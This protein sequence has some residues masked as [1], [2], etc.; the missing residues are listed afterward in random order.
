MLLMCCQV[1]L[2]ARSPKHYTSCVMILTCIDWLHLR[3]QFRT[4]SWYIDM[5]KLNCP[6]N[7]HFIISRLKLWEKKLKE[8]FHGKKKNEING[9]VLLRKEYGFIQCKRN[10]MLCCSII[11][12]NELKY[13]P[14]K[15]II[16]EALALLI[17]LVFLND[18][19][20]LFLVISPWCMN[21]LS[22][23][24]SGKEHRMKR[25]ERI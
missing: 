10:S 21:L 25:W 13:C 20:I 18:A 19:L 17:F 8:W 12:L 22:F 7:F 4:C 11:V 1:M 14:K 6:R 15:P 9:N 23:L 2:P 24:I 16:C 3:D 5:V